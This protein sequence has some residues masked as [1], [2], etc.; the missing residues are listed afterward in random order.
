MAETAPA[1]AHF[2]SHPWA[3]TLLN[4]TDYTPI[5]TDS[6]QIKPAT[7]EDGYFAN[8]LGTPSTI[9]H[10]LTLQRRNIAP[11][12][13]EIPPWLPTTKPKP[14]DAPVQ[15]T[16]GATP[17]DV[18]ML[19]D[20]GAPGLS[21]HPSIV[22]GGIVATLIDEA[23]SLAVAAHCPAPVSTAEGASARGRTFTAQLDVRYRQ[24]VQTPALLVIRAKVVAR[25]GKKFWVRAQAVQEDEA[26]AGG[27]LEW[28][29]RKIVKADAMAF[30]IV[31]PAEKI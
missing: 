5:P 31:L 11:I 17:A 22:H 10:L 26:S 28:T 1:V 2:R 4:S 29:K 27:H 25:N 3:N 7:G 8:T 15:P 6:R 21:G 30:W 19:C 23:M 18:L 20:L 14:D 12:P 16:P 24:P 9:P 13:S